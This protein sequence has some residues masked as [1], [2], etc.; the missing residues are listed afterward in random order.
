MIS[1]DLVD[2]AAKALQESVVDDVNLST[3]WGKLLASLC[4]EQRLRV[5]RK[6]PMTDTRLQ[7][8]VDGSLSQGMSSYAAPTSCPGQTIGANAAGGPGHDQSKDR[9]VIG[10]WDESN[11]PDLLGLGDH[12]DY[13]ILP[14]WLGFP[15]DPSRNVNDTSLFPTNFPTSWT[16]S[17][18]MFDMLGPS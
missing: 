6:H 3:R 7:R 4:Y 18:G 12:D 14:D 17:E 1:F 15:P 11:L 8:Q 2:G 16:S 10:L 9:D 13:F 5:A